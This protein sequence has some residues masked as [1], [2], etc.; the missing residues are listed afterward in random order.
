MDNRIGYLLVPTYAVPAP[1]PVISIPAYPISA[2]QIFPAPLIMQPPGY[3]QL[4]DN[5]FNN[6]WSCQ[7][8]EENEYINPVMPMQ[9][10]WAPWPTND[11]HDQSAAEPDFQ[12]KDSSNPQLD[13]RVNNPINDVKTQIQE[14]K[15]QPE[16][17]EEVI[18][19]EKELET[20]KNTN[21]EDF[22]SI[23]DESDYQAEVKPTSGKNHQSKQ[24]RWKKVNDK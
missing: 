7:I 3:I 18:E 13:S 9:E 23:S 20:N 8:A 24:I 4:P 14:S 22:I 6:I 21:N 17:K 1:V 11:E 15:M 19:E 2:Y 10:F 12:Y 5:S 16:V